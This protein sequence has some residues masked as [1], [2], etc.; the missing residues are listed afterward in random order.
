MSSSVPIVQVSNHL[1]SP[2]LVASAFTDT[3]YRQNDPV[4]SESV[5]PMGVDESTET[6]G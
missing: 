3:V 2:D 5:G 1:T 6:P 4:T